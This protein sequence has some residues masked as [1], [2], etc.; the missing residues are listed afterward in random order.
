MAIRTIVSDLNP[1]LIPQYWDSVLGENLYPSLYL[2]QFGT[3][4]TLPRNFGTT[5]KIPRLLKRNIVG[6]LGAGEGVVVGTSGISSQHVSG[7]LQQFGGAY[8]H[9]DL[10][11]MTAL[12]DVVELSLRDIARDLAKR[13]DTHVRDTLSGIGLAVY[14]GGAA[15]GSGGS[16]TGK[17]RTTDL[18]KS[19]ALL[20]TRD[21]SRPPDGHYPV[22]THPLGIYDLQSSLTGNSWLEI[23]KGTSDASV[24]QLYR[25]EI[26][27]VFG[28][29]LVTST[30]TKR[31]VGAA[32]QGLSTAVSGYRSFMFAPDSY[33]VTEVNDMTAKTFV[34]QLGSGGSLDPLNQVATVGAK[35]FFTAI[36]ANWGS[37]GRMVRIIH[38]SNV[39]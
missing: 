30:N 15:A 12:S 34:K 28:A 14:G 21:N 10:V 1:S 9:S 26:G 8:R 6:L 23:N 25:G 5:I 19:A 13:M 39:T 20:D 18:L 22:V 38:A 31:L 7:T 29:R 2:Y 37:E 11:I 32:G 35:V 16:A 3:K 4:R 36:P 24:G 17:L 27:R 33:Y